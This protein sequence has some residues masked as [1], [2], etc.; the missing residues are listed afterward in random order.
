MT[1]SIDPV[2]LTLPAGGTRQF[3]V[4]VV[5]AANTAVTWSVNGITGGNAT[6]GTISGPGLYAAPAVPPAGYA[7]TVK[8]TSAA[9]P[10]AFAAGTVTVRNQIPNV[11]SVAP[12]PLPLGPF[13]ITVNGSRFVSGAQVMWNNTPLPTNF[14]STSQL[15]ATG[16]AAQ[17]GSFNVTVA[18][19]GPGA[20]ST[21]LAVKVVSSVV[22]VV[23]PS[24]VGLVPA[25]TQQFQANV[26]GTP[27]TAVTWKVNG[28][29]GGDA[30]VGTI[31]QGGLY[32][33]PA[34]IPTAG[35]VTVS[36]LS[37]ADNVTQGTA[38]VTIQ[39]PLAVTYGRFLDQ[40]T[41]GATPQLMAHV[42]QVGI[43]AF[44]DEQFA[45][46]ESTWPSLST[47]QR[48]DAVDAFFNNALSGQDQLRQ[49]VIFALSEIIVVAMNKNTNGNE[50]VPWLQ[51]LSRNAFGNY[52]TLL[53]EI[54]LDASMGKY[55]DLA[56]SARPGVS[57]GANE[58]YAREVMQ[59][60]S[61]GLWKLNQDGSQQLDAQ[62]NPI[63]T[64]D[65]T[66]VKQMALALTGWTYG[67]S[68]GTPPAY[69][70]WNYYPGPML[71]LAS[72]HDRTQKTVLG[73]TLPANQTNVQDL[74]GAL[75]II[76][77]HPNVGPF[78]ATRLIRALVTSNPSPAYIAR[79]A[80]AFNDNGQG[81]RGDMKAVIRAILTD[82]EARDDNPP[83]SFG[84]LRTPVQHTIAFLRA[85]NITPGQPS[86]FAYVFYS[87]GE[88]M[89][90]APSVFGHY[91][92]MYHVPRS[93][94][95]GPEFQIYSP[96]EAVNRANFLYSWMGNPWPINPALQPFVSVAS[97]P[98]ALVNAVDNALL[99]GRMSPQMRTALVNAM[100]AMYDNNQRVMTVLYLTATSGD[101]L[102]QH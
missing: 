96:T 26:S 97:N 34:A 94:L 23:T 45:L 1:V 37:Q 74:D 29:T 82:A 87:F 81:V 72:Y 53:R 38:A 73:Q 39:D 11:T 50:I 68:S 61:I 24:S 48:S 64:Y 14:V 54:T 91:S 57:G 42:R 89:L 92:P 35:A 22:V 27:N 25:A 56:N 41:F 6:V 76:F 75:D 65:Q 66:D 84:R 47:A 67:N 13:T 101:Y 58:N 77:N 43:P 59:L 98:A 7:V 99:Y 5:G 51:L 36:A 100:P 63:P 32:T 8:A 19:P 80:A 102:V 17:T 55:L 44:I 31:T 69:Q 10:T 60:F 90:D 15:T 86:Q 70:N 83:A 95:F 18:N 46:P 79:V 85:L 88:G 78:L 4:K 93:P 40:A 49:R 52:R 16:N 33:A 3:S 71:P 62:G 12:S 21:A 2:N 9:D 28:T 30:T 20:V